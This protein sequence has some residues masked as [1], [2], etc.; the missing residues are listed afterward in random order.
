VAAD[1]R[2]SSRKQPLDKVQLP[3]R[4]RGISSCHVAKERLYDIHRSQGRLSSPGDPPIFPTI[5]SDQGGGPILP[6]HRTHVRSS[7]SV[8]GI[9]EAYATYGALPSSARSS[10]TPISRRLLGSCGVPGVINPTDF[11]LPPAITAAGS[12]AQSQEVS[13]GSSETARP[14]GHGYRHEYSVFQSSREKGNFSQGTCET[15]ADLCTIPSS[16]GKQAVFGQSSG[17]GHVPTVSNMEGQNFMPLALP[18]VS[19]FNSLD[20]GCSTITPGDERPR[21]FA[22]VARQRHG[23]VHGT[24]SH[25]IYNL[26]RRQ[27]SSLGGHVGHSRVDGLF[28]FRRKRAPHNVERTLCGH[29]GSSGSGFFSPRP[30][31]F[32]NDGQSGGPVS[33]EQGDQQVASTYVGVS[34]DFQTPLPIRRSIAGEVSSYQLERQG[35]LP[36]SS[37]SSLGVGDIQP[38]IRPTGYSL[39]VTRC[40]PLRFRSDNETTDFQQSRQGPRQ[41][42]RCNVRVMERSVELHQSPVQHDKGCG[43]E[44]AHGPGGEYSCT[45]LLAQP[46]MVAHPS[47]TCDGDEDLD[48]SRNQSLCTTEVFSGSRDSPQPSVETSSTI[49][50]ALLRSAAGLL[51]SSLRPSSRSTYSRHVQKYMDV[52]SSASVSPFPVSID[53]ASIFVAKYFQ[54]NTPNTIRSMWSAVVKQQFALGHRPVNQEITTLVSRLCRG[55]ANSRAEVVGPVFCRQFVRSSA[56]RACYDAMIAGLSSCLVGDQPAFAAV[57]FGFVLCLRSASLVQLTLSDIVLDH[58]FFTVCVRYHKSRSSPVA[59][60]FSIPRVAPFVSGL[61]QYVTWVRQ[62]GCFPHQSLFFLSP[63]VPGAN[64]AATISTILGR[65][66]PRFTS[67]PVSQSHLLRRSA[68]IAMLAVGVVITRIISWGGWSSHVSVMPYLRDNAN[69]VS[70][71]D[72]VFFFGWLRGQSSF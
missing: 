56:I 60:R 71:D 15:V 62:R 66:L 65:V 14:L 26:H 61:C 67:V 55:A 21:S 57:V 34:G 4:D 52:C 7:S 36:L 38:V 39:R 44:S 12:T 23:I 31:R 68:A 25:D 54:S 33:C 5:C 24:S 35:G 63:V 50:A 70:S 49:R 46:T 22:E 48:D 43:E 59:R 1:H 41:P 20:G 69:I 51:T 27:R 3:L 45:S 6:V 72:D 30:T 13:A 9:H 10:S 40:R 11:F 37:S 42:R 47:T 19:V 2:S 28:R 58:D 64:S 53:S 32:V 8:L 17:H 29:Q 16:M 18:S